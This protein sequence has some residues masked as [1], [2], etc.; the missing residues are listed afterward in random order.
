METIRN[1]YRDIAHNELTYS[2]DMT[3]RKK[4]LHYIIKY[5]G[6]Q[7][8]K[9]LKNSHMDAKRLKDALSTLKETEEIY[10]K[11]KH[12]FWKDS[13]DSQNENNP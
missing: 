11:D 4:I 3:D 6:I 10:E 1:D 12:Y 13:Q 7:Y 8:S 9:L 2:K 5:P